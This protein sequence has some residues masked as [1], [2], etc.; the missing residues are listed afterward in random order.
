MS[1]LDC[2]IVWRYKNEPSGF[3]WNEVELVEAELCTTSL[4]CPMRV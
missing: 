2:Y 3:L 4:S 1:Q